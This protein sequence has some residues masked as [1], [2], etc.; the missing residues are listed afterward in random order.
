ME[1]I[2]NCIED[3]SPI[4]YI[5]INAFLPKNSENEKVIQQLREKIGA[6]SKMPVTVGFGPRYLHST[7][8]FHKGGPNTGLFI[9]ITSQRSNDL[10][11]PGLGVS[12]GVMQ[13]AQAIGDYQALMAK[14]RKVLW[15]DL[16]E[17]DLAVLLDK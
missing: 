13:R 3:K 17:P 11:I 10:D 6:V 9:L 5:A 16:D 12:F 2:L 14:G 4:E 7:G 15:L 1:L 8:Q